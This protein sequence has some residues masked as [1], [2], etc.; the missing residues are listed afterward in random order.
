MASPLEEYAGAG[1]HRAGCQS[2]GG[3][4]VAYGGS[5]LSRGV[6]VTLRS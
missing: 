1:V 3:S 6:I 4:R 2:G 5:P